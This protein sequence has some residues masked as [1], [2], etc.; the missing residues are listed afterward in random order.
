[1]AV[2]VAITEN[3]QASK[4]AREL[5]SPAI[6]VVLEIQRTRK[7]VGGSNVP[8]YRMQV[9]TPFLRTKIISIFGT[10]KPSPFDGSGW[11]EV[12]YRLPREE[13]LTKLGLIESIQVFG[14]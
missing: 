1:M 10:G 8:V 13:I 9:R 5:V 12:M 14:D 4:L 11:L 2:N 3:P 6:D 7:I